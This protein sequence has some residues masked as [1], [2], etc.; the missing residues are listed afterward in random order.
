VKNFYKNKFGKKMHMNNQIESAKKILDDLTTLFDFLETSDGKSI[1]WCHCFGGVLEFIADKTFSLDYDIDIGVMYGE[2]DESKLIYALEGHGYKAEKKCINDVNKKSF[3]IH[4]TPREET[5]KGT[6]T[7]DVYFW[8]PIGDKYYHTY[9]TKKE[10]NKIPSEYVFKGVKKWW[11]RPSPEVIK[12]EKN[13]GKPGRE[14]LFT[15]QGTWKFPVFD[16]SGGLTMRLPY[17]IGHLLDTWYSPTWRFR[18][19]YK[20]QSM[21]P[22]IKK[23]KSCRELEQ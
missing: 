12:M 15:D 1:W 5:L 3:N 7:V 17:A 2:C 6:P 22:W 23:V 14:Q 10:G 18:E 20:G 4:F 19:Y 9:D 16:S 13:R 8:V 11:L 21:S